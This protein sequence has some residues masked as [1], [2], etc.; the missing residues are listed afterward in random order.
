[1]EIFV[2]RKKMQEWLQNDEQ[3]VKQQEIKNINNM[4]AKMEVREKRQEHKET[5]AAEDKKREQRRLNHL[6]RVRET[7]DQREYEKCATSERKEIE[8]LV[9]V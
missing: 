9:S 5:V 6:H 7:I 8:C 3:R 1:M 4:K 2:R